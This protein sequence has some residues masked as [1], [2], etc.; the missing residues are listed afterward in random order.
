MP[1]QFFRLF[2][3]RL[4][5]VQSRQKRTPKSGC[6][7]VNEETEAIGAA[8]VTTLRKTQALAGAVGVV[9]ATA[10]QRKIGERVVWFRRPL[11]AGRR[12]ATQPA[13]AIRLSVERITI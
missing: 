5:G 6:S 12:E 10:E 9:G 4:G 1:R 11:E 7:S 8:R 2:F 3:F 13:R